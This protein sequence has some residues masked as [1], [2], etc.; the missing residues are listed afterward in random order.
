MAAAGDDG[1]DE[2]TTGATV[3]DAV[4]GAVYGALVAK[5][6]YMQDDSFENWDRVQTAASEFH[7][8][9]GL[10][11]YAMGAERGEERVDIEMPERRSDSTTTDASSPFATETARRI[12]ETSRRAGWLYNQNELHM[13]EVDRRSA[14]ENRIG[15]LVDEHVGLEGTQAG[16][17]SVE[18]TLNDVADRLA[19]DEA[20][21]GSKRRKIAGERLEKL[22]R[23]LHNENEVR[24]ETKQTEPHL[25]RLREAD[26]RNG[27]GG[28]N[29][30]ERGV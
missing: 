12:H 16:E 5:D 10:A 19:V 4:V 24:P 25:D 18:D 9:I 21:D 29:N 13:D 2:H 15:E 8:S 23:E 11:A 20:L 28:R 26:E 3:R 7:Q 30:T 1:D 22:S 27:K 14:A 6:E 17:R